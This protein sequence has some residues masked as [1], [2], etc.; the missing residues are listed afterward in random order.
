ML[1]TPGGIQK[2]STDQLYYVEVNG[3]YLYYHTAHGEFRQKASMKELEDKEAF[4]SEM[5]HDIMIY[6]TAVKT[7]NKALDNAITAVMQID[8]PE[9]RV[10]SLKTITK[11]KLLVI[12]IENYFDTALHFEEGLSLTTKYNQQ[13]HGFGMKSIRYIAEKYGGAITVNT[14]DHIFTLQILIP[15]KG[16]SP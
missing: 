11:N 14:A 3:H 7:G 2:I 13:D 10:V 8:N 1:T 4:L 12:Q 15:L 6:D 5:E 16:V 9:M